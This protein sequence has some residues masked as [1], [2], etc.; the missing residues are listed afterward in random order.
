MINCN[1]ISS[2]HWNVTGYIFAKALGIDQFSRAGY[3]S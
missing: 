3:A 2:K 1:L